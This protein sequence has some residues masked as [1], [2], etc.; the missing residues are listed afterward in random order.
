MAEAP[1]FEFSDLDLNYRGCLPGDKASRILDVGCGQGRV[2]AFLRRE[3]YHNIVG[4]D[5]DPAAIEAAARFGVELHK[6]DDPAV[7]L[8]NRAETFDLIIAKDVLYYFPRAAV[9]GVIR[10]L[11][12]ALRPGGVLLAET[13]NGAAFAGP[14][15]AYKDYRI[16]WIPTEFSLREMFIDAGFPPPE[17]AGLASPAR[18]LRR[19]LFNAAGRVLNFATMALFVVA[20]GFDPQNPTIFEKKIIVRARRR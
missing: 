10:A 7:F 18:T 3:G 12:R 19:R 11:S 8:E 2:L 16:E 20:R 1:Q 5:R 13:F 14:W 6:V 15:V 9:P 4:I 17:I